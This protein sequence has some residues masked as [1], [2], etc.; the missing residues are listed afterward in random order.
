GVRELLAAPV[1]ALRHAAELDRTLAPLAER[2][3]TLGYEADDLGGELRRYALELDGTDGGG[4][5]RLEEGEERLELVARLKR[6][7]R[8][9]IAD[10]LDHAAPRAARRDGLRLGDVAPDG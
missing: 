1:Q 5:G 8:G 9:S 10:V 7:H 4:R 3:S 6:K 2:L